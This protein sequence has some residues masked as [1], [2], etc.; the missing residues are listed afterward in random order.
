MKTLLPICAALLFL[1][2]SLSAAEPDPKLAA[3]GY[4]VLKTYCYRC[5]GV[6]FDVEGYN[7]LNRD[8]LLN[9]VPE[10][11]EKARYIVP[12]KPDASLMWQRTGA[13]KDMP[14]GS[15][16]KPSADELATLK[17]W[18]ESGAPFPAATKRTF[19]TEKDLYSY[20]RDDLRATERE[21]R[22]FRRYFS[23]ANLNNNAYEQ[24]VG[25]NGK[26]FDEADLRLARA[27]FAK[28]ANSLSWKPEIVVPRIVD[29]GKAEV[30]LSIDL[31]DLGWD[32]RHLWIEILKCNP[33]AL[34]Q[35]TSADDQLREMANEIYEM[36]G[37]L[38][39]YVRV[40]WFLDTAARPPLYHTM[41]GLPETAQE[42]EKLL[43]VDVE[44]D[45]LREK[46]VRAGF[47]ESGVSMSNR[48]VDRHQ[49]LYGA[50][51]K[52]YDFA[53]SEG[54]G[55]LFSHPLGPKF[56]A[57]PYDRQA[58][59][60]AGGEMIFNLPNGMQGYYLTDNQGKRLDKGPVEI[61]RDLKETAGSPEVVNGIS[62]MACHEHGV[63]RFKD[64]I[65]DG[66]AVFDDAR[67]KVQ[68]LFPKSADM[69]RWLDKDEARFMRS[70]EDAAGSFLRVGPDQDRAVKSFPEPVGF[71]A[72]Y[73]QKDLELEDAAA[74][75]GFAD[76]KELMYAIKA[77]PD[78]R[79]LGLGPLLQGAAIKRALWQSTDRSITPFQRTANKLELGTP[80][81]QQ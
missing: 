61:V 43:K 75:L 30:L 64:T 44:G 9:K 19:V 36:T 3:A 21:D 18:I 12:G 60:H 15:N 55:N 76:P 32:E 38:V 67:Q 17:Q 29:K 72:R 35:T 31:R 47:A 28:L 51:W 13:K 70:Y 37:T 81:S 53:K 4:N 48:L 78:L 80:H 33:Y 59:V 14:P 73:F 8:I 79:E 65:R 39:P 62:C 11:D 77:N 6:K 7:V 2:A 49:A 57:N 68:R 63:I 25:K 66:L 41:L 27:A 71:L 46:L 34:K 42:V 1:P 56:K 52:S 40:D 74:E 24:R 54:E 20:I 69:K 16:A 22:R 10:D 58:F 23:L 45:F 5:H 26:N 50:Y